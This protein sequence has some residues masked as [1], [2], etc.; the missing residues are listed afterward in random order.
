MLCN[1]F[2]SIYS[3]FWTHITLQDDD[4]ERFKSQFQQYIDD[5]IDADGLQELYESAHAKIREDPNLPDPDASN[6][7]PAE[8]WK[9]ESK[10][11]KLTKIG[12]EQR[13]ENVKTKIAELQAA[14]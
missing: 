4:E 13:M 10:K 12:R 7:K 11:H 3:K 8:F 6:R 1:P 9:A 5:E 14:A 2:P